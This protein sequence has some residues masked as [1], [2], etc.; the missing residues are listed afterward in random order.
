MQVQALHLAVELEEC[1]RS[2]SW[3]LSISS[4]LA[5]TSCLALAY[6]LALA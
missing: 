6:T 1:L 5:A 4:S 3:Q 2:F